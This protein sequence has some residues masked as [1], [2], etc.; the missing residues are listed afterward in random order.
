M[1]YDVVSN[2]YT[3]EC[4]MGI[5]YMYVRMYIYLCARK[6]FYIGVMYILCIYMYIYARTE[7]GAY[8][9]VCIWS[10]RL[11]PMCDGIRV[12]IY[13]Y[14]YIYIYARVWLFVCGLVQVHGPMGVQMCTCIICI[15]Y[16]SV[17]G[18]GYRYGCFY[19][20]CIYTYIYARM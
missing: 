17:C 14:V 20:L 9:Y 12:G 18:Y 1:G 15:L 3:H 2:A 5:W 19:I 16:T 4:T 10:M 8:V 6:R 11:T 13:G 7:V